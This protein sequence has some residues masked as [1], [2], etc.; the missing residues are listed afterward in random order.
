MIM[1]VQEVVNCKCHFSFNAVILR[2]PCSL[3]CAFDKHGC[4]MFLHIRK[5]RFKVIT[6]SG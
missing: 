1:C 5:E 2:L 6:N 4:S 3:Q